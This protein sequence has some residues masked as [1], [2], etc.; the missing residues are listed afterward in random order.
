MQGYK[1]SRCERER[2]RMVMM[3]YLLF[4]LHTITVEKKYNE[5]LI[6]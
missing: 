1:R 2:E 5:G 4:G 6:Q 3:I